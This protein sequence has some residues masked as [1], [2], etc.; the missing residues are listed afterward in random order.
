MKTK[1]S[2]TA[3]AQHNKICCNITQHGNKHGYSFYDS[4][5]PGQTLQKQ[6]VTELFEE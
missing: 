3:A 5:I 2:R 6:N 1:M 4:N